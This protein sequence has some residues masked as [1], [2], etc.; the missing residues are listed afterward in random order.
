MDQMVDEPAVMADSSGL[1]LPSMPV[2]LSF[3]RKSA[4]ATPIW[5]LAATSCCSALS[6]SGR[7]S[8]RAEGSPAGTDGT[9]VWAKS[10]VPRGM[11][12]GF[13][14]SSVLIWF[15]LAAI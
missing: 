10:G 15:S 8:I 13:L 11:G 3:G 9:T 14:P 5:A 12:P 2:R 1:A 7:R 4:L 6:R